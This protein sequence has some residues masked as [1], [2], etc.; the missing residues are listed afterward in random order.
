MRNPATGEVLSEVPQ[1]SGEDLDEALDGSLRA[2]AIW[3]KTAALDRAAVLRRAASLLR[4]RLPELARH[5]TLEQGKTLAESRLEFELSAEALEWYAAEALR[6]NGRIIPARARGA[7]QMVIPQPVGPVAAFTPWN[8]P[9][10]LPARK[11]GA[12]LA[13]GC[14]VIIKPSEETP[15][16][17]IGLAKALMDAGL[18]EGTLNLVLGIPAEVSR[19]LIQSPIIRK[20]TFTGSTPVG[21]EI[22]QLAA[23]YAKPCTLELGGHA[24]VLVFDDADLD[25]A[26]RTCAI[27]KT[28]NAGQVC[29]SPTR[30]YVQD[31]IY[32]EFS[33]GFAEAMNAM[34]VGPGMAPESQMG[35]LANVR[36]MTA[37]ES[38]VDDAHA[39]GGKIIAGGERLADVGYLW[40]PTVISDVP[41]SAR[42]MQVEPFG[43]LALVNRFNTLEEGLTLANNHPF[44]LAAYAFTQ[45]S[46]TAAAIADELEAGG[47]GINTF[48]VA[49]IEA[50]FGGVKDSGYGT[51]GGHEGLEAYMHPK[52]VHHAP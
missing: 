18:P 32:Q 3:R 46:R 20:V 51:E 15:A 17:T 12:A 13:A 42:A 45:S 35:A 19:H 50:P 6:A 1:A 29:T 25:H 24:P 14:A 41:S 22:A 11:I 28:R 48:A 2:F 16:S 36:R 43:P 23:A 52:Y 33:S 5:M 49:Q 39:A 8:F 27:G 10:V 26:I 9:A 30:F 4:E 31:R 44:G 40:R 21:R 47:I 34:K 37:I 7:R 38:L